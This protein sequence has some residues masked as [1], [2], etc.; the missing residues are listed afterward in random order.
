MD[1]IELFPI[2]SEKTFR[3]S[4]EFI[5]FIK[6]HYDPATVKHPLTVVVGLT[7]LDRTS[8]LSSLHRY[9]FET[10]QAFGEVFRLKAN[11][12]D[13]RVLECY[14]VLNTESGV[15]Y[16]FT[17]FRKTEEIPKINEFLQSEPHSYYLFFSSILIEKAIEKVDSQ[18]AG[19]T[20]SD[21][22]A[23]RSPNTKVLARYRPYV[24]RT[25]SYWGEDGKETLSEMKYAYGVLVQRA[26][27]DIPERCKFGID[28][29]G[30]MT[31]LSGSMECPLS[32]L[33]EIIEQA[34]KARSAYATSSYRT[35]TAGSSDAPL[36][37]GVSSPATISLSDPLAYDRIG[38]FFDRLESE[39]FIVVD[40]VAEEGS[41]FFSSN[42]MTPS[43]IRSRIKSDGS[44]IRMFP[45]DERNLQSFMQFYE[46]ILNQIDPNARLE[47]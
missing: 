25:V 21:F 24:K 17:N 8:L 47:A 11:I 35:A 42:I 29:R 13:G 37:I 18:F 28:G 1:E 36:K 16:F 34:R 15:L 2:P 14:V 4:E 38:D 41:L 46:F 5:D 3:D 45:D 33:T 27:I 10:V 39:G 26:I 12:E 23:R 19:V 6:R 9:G 40:S 20:I 44:K 31:F 30:F 7:E 32:I 22:T 43:G